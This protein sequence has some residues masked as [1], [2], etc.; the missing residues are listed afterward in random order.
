MT[1]PAILFIMVDSR[2]VNRQADSSPDD[3]DRELCL[4]AAR[5]DPQAETELVSRYGQLVRA[6]ARPLFL[7]GG[8]SEDLIQEGMLGLLTAIRGFDPQRDTLFRTYAEICIRSRLYTAIRAAQG[9]KHAP[10]NHSVSFE[11]PLFDEVCE[12][13]FSG[14]ESPED[15]IIGREELRELLDTLKERLTPLER[16]IFSPYLKG[17]S[18]GEIARQV[19]RPQKSVDNAIQRIRRKMV[20]Q[21]RSGVIS[22]S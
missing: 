1:N 7:A 21:L 18:C 4:R 12:P 8:D 6:C 11:P 10:L 22:R 19:D 2:S 14:G 16:Q 15:V 20:R 5:G 3:L 9:G 17:L 13:T